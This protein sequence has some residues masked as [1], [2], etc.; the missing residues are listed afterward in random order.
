LGE[1]I[2]RA[3]VAGSGQA[4]AALADLLRG[5]EMLAA[6]EALRIGQSFGLEPGM[7]LD[8]GEGLSAVGPLV[9]GIL[10][11][12]VLTRQFDSGLALGHLLK[13]L[14]TASSVAQACGVEAP[15][16][17]ACRDT[18]A[19]AETRR[20]WP[21]GITGGKRAALCAAQAAAHS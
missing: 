14:E 3:G 6:T 1:R 17:A 4:A 9:G 12:Q 2:L 11:R 10:R 8:I 18:W 20:D 21:A 7:L 5:A 13:G 19:A 16:L 15:L